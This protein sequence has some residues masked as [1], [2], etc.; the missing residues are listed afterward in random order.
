MVAD[1][2]QRADRLALAAFAADVDGQIDDDLERVERDAGLELPQV[3]HRQLAQ[4]LA[5]P[6]DA[7]RVDHRRLE[8]AVDGDDRGAGRHV[9]PRRRFP[10]G[11][12]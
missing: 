7:E 10:A 5:E 11:P 4:V 2:E 8:A 6:D 9:A 3:A 1:D 12:A